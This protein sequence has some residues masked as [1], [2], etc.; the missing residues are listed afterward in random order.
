MILAAL[1]PTLNRLLLASLL[2]A[3]AC[4]AT[5]STEK[6]FK[7]DAGTFTRVDVRAIAGSLTVKKGASGVVNAV[8]SW[9]GDVQPEI[10]SR[11]AGETLIVSSECP[12]KAK[13][14]SVDLELT[15]PDTT[16]V[17]IEKVD[18]DV[19]VHDIAGDVD[20]VA[21]NGT[22]SLIDV[23]G[24]ARLNLIDVDLTLDGVTGRFDVA[25][26]HGAVK[27]Q[28]LSAPTA[29]VSAQKGDVDLSF[30]TIPD[31]VD[32]TTDVSDILVALPNGD[33]DI[34]DVSRRGTVTIDG[35]TNTPDAGSVIVAHSTRGNIVVNGR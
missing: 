28:V 3:A 23:S 9:R 2:A 22:L 8:L 4:Q 1:E 20:V 26:D 24:D 29:S 16:A 33:Y 13:A 12:L 11:L 19:E 31:L 18:G 35:L 27:G 30:T 14:C 15:V 32:V 5:D 25:S 17:D 34:D 6:V 21:E 7:Y 10:S